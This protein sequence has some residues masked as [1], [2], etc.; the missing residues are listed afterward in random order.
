M[1]QNWPWTQGLVLSLLASLDGARVWEEW[2]VHHVGCGGLWS[3][4]ML[5]STRAHCNGR[6][7][8]LSCVGE[9]ALMKG[10]AGWVLGMP[11]PQ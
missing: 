4:T 11:T 9:R 6:G 3:T 5:P 1:W 10:A 8:G 2:R 7:S